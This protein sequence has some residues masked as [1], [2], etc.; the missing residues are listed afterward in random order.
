MRG[1][2]RFILAWCWTSGVLTSFA[3]TNDLIAEIR[4]IDDRTLVRVANTSEAYFVFVIATNVPSLEVNP[5]QAAVV[6]RRSSITDFFFNNTNP[7]QRQFF[8]TIR[9]NSNCDPLDNDNDGIDD[10]IE[11]ILPYL[12]PS[13]RLDAGQDTDGDGWD[14]RTE[15]YLG[16]NPADA[17][18]SYGEI[19]RTRFAPETGSLAFD[20][21]FV[22]SLADDLTSP[23]RA[24]G[25][26]RSGAVWCSLNGDPYADLATVDPFLDL[27]E[28]YLG[29]TDG[30]LSAHTNLPSGAT[31]PLVVEAM[32]LIG[33]PSTDLVIGH[34]D[35]R[36]TFFEG[37]GAGNLLYRPDLTRSNLGAVVALAA[38]DLDGDGDNDLVVSGGAQ[39]TVLFNNDDPVAANA[40]QNGDFADQLRGWS[41]LSGGVV[42]VPRGAAVFE[43]R[44]TFLTGIEQD[45]ILPPAPDALTFDVLEAALSGP[46]GALPDVLEVALLDTEGAPLLPPFRAASESLFNIS[47][48]RDPRLAAGVSIT[49]NRVSINL[50]SVTGDVPATLRF[51][52]IGSPGP[53]ALAAIDNVSI[54]PELVV[55][56][57]WS[58]TAL[59]GPFSQS[60]GLVITDPDLDGDL[61]ILVEDGGLGQL[62]LFENLGTG[63]L[64]RTPLTAADYGCPPSPP[65]PVGFT[66]TVSQAKY[67]VADGLTRQLHPYLAD[68]TSRNPVSTVSGA[69]IQALETSSDG[70]RTWVNHPGSA[71][72]W[73]F[74]ANLIPLGSWIAAGVSN[75]LD[76][77]AAGSDLW[78]LDR[79]VLFLGGDP[80][81]PANYIE[82]HAMLRFPGAVGRV[83]GTATSDFQWLVSAA[84]GDPRHVMSDGLGLHLLDT[85]SNRVHRLDFA[86]TAQGSWALD[87]IN[88]NPRGLTRSG[89][90]IIIADR[91]DLLVYRYPNGVNQSSGT[92]VAVV[93]FALSDSNFEPVDISDPPQN[94]NLDEEVDG[95]FP[96]G[97]EINEYLFV[98]TAPTSILVE[99]ISIVGD[100]GGEGGGFEPAYTL[101]DPDGT[102]LADT[103]Y[104]ERGP[105]NLTET[106]TYSFI[107]TSAGE[108]TGTYTVV[109]RAINPGPAI[110]ITPGE[111]VEDGTSVAG[112]IDRFSFAVSNDAAFYF[113]PGDG[114]FDLLWRL[115]APDGSV[116]TD[117]FWFEVGPVFL[118]A[119]GT[120][121][122]D[123]W[124]LPQNT[125]DYSFTASL[126]ELGSPSNIVF[127]VV[128]SNTLTG[129]PDLDVYTFVVSSQAVIFADYISGESFSTSWDLRGPDT[130]TVFADSF[131]DNSP[132]FLDEP[133]TYTLFIGSSSVTGDYSFSIREVAAPVTSLVFGVNTTGTVAS[134]GG[135][136]R[137]EFTMETNKWLNFQRISGSSGLFQW[138]LL[139]PAGSNVFFMT[140]FGNTGPYMLM[141]TGRYEL[142]IYGRNGG[143]GTVVFRV[144]DLLIQP[145]Q[146]P[147]NIL[148]NTEISATVSNAYWSNRYT[149]VLSE[150]TTLIFNRISGSST[151]F[152][153]RL[154]DPDQNEVFDNS[155]FSLSPEPY[156]ATGTYELVVYNRS[157]VV[158]VSYTFAVE[159]L[160]AQP[161]PEVIFPDLVVTS[162]I[163]EPFQIRTYLID[164][165]EGQ[166]IK[167]EVRSGSSFVYQ[168]EMTDPSSNQIFGGGFSSQDAFIAAT[169]GTYQVQVSAFGSDVGEVSFILYDVPADPAPV[170]LVFDQT[171]GP[172]MIPGQTHTYTFAITNPTTVFFNNEEFSNQNVYVAVNLKSPS[173]ANIFGPGNGQDYGTFVLTEPGTYTLLVEGTLYTGPYYFQLWDVPQHEARAIA[174]EEDVSAVFDAPGE[175][176]AFTFE[177]V[178]GETVY[179]E[180]RYSTNTFEARL[181]GPSGALLKT[182]QLNADMPSLVLP[183][184]GTYR[185]EF[186]F[187]GSVFDPYSGSVAFRLWRVTTIS[188]TLRLSDVMTG[189]IPGPAGRARFTF[190]AAAGE[191]YYFDK[192]DR[193]GDFGQEGGN[194]TADFHWILR[195]PSSAIVFSSAWANAG[196]RIMPENGTYTLEIN[197]GYNRNDRLFQFQVWP[198][199]TSPVQPIARGVV[200]NGAL[201]A[202][203][204]TNR[205]SF[206]AT[207]GETIVV[208][209]FSGVGDVQ[210]LLVSPSGTVLDGPQNDA[211]TS[212]VLAETG[213]FEVRVVDNFATTRHK[214]N[215][216]SFAMDLAPLPLTA[217]ASAD[218]AVTN[219]T[220][221]PVSV[222]T[223]VVMDVVWTV[224]NR[225]ATA[226]SAT[227]WMDRIVLSS[228][229]QLYEQ[230]DEWYIDV[231][232]S[233]GLAGNGFYTA[234]QGVALPPGFEG[235]LFVSVLTDAANVEFESNENN[236]IGLF[237][238]AAIYTADRVLSNSA[239]ID[240]DIADGSRYPQGSTILV[241]GRAS[242]VAASENIVFMLDASG[243]TFIFDQYDANFDGVVDY[244]D[245]INSDLLL[246]PN[247]FAIKG[248]LGSGFD[249][250]LGSIY[251]LAETL[252]ALGSDLRYNILVWA[253]EAVP[254]D[255]S[256]GAFV[257]S[258]ARSGDNRNGNSVVDYKEAS[259]T[260]LYNN[261]PILF[262]SRTLVGGYSFHVF[263]PGNDMQRAFDALLELL[264]RAQPVGRTRVFFLADNNPA[265][266][267]DVSSNTVAQLAA[268]G[269]TLEAIQLIN[270]APVSVPMQRVADIVDADTNST[271]RARALDNSNDLLEA[272]L[273]T[274]RVA[275]VT[276]NDVGVQSFDD[277]GRFF[278]PYVVQ[279]G[280]QDLV[281]KAYD[282]RGNIVSRTVT[283]HGYAGS[284]ATNLPLSDLGEGLSLEYPNATWRAGDAVLDAEM[285]AVNRGVFA[286]RTPLEAWFVGV[287]PAGAQLLAP[288]RVESGGVPVIALDAAGGD[289]AP[290]G[291]GNVFSVSVANPAAERITLE[292]IVYGP[293][294]QAPR[295]VAAPP[296]S[297]IAG[298]AWSFAVAV[299]D[300]EGDPVT[301]ELLDAPAGMIL[302][303]AT[304]QWSTVP[305][306]EGNHLVRVRATDDRGGARE[307]V[308][309][310]AC[311][312]D[313]GNRP[314]VFLSAP[315]T[316]LMSGNNY[317]YTPVVNDPDGDSLAFQLIGSP[318]GFTVNATNG[319]VSYAAIPDGLYALE[320]EADD[321]QGGVTVQAFDLRVGAGSVNVSGPVIL[322]TPPV[323]AVVGESYG[324]FPSAYDP[325]GDAVTFALLQ[326]PSGMT[327]Q[328][329]GGAIQWTPDATQT[330]SFAVLLKVSDPSG[331]YASQ[332]FTIQSGTNRLNRAPVM[333]REPLR[334]ATAGTLYEAVIAAVDPDGEP[335]NYSLELGPAGMAVD[336]GTG[337]VSWS[338]PPLLE[339]LV[340]ARVYAV[341][342][343]G[344][345]AYLTWYPDVRASNTPPQFTGAPATNVPAGALYRQV[346]RVVDAEDGVTFD[347]ITDA[348]GLVIDERTGVLRWS[349]SVQDIGVYTVTVTATDDRGLA[350]TWTYSLQVVPDTTAP[351]VTLT[352]TP[353]L[354]DVGETSVVRVAASDDVGVASLAILA[355]ASNLVVDGNGEAMVVAAAPG[356]IMVTGLAVDAAGNTGTVA[357]AL[358]VIDPSDT[359]TPVII[360]TAPTNQATV[361]AWTEI[362][363][364][365]T[366]PEG[367]LDYFTV[368][369]APADALEQVPTASGFA[370]D[371]DCDACFTEVFRTNTPVIDDTLAFLD[372]SLYANNDYAIRVKAFDVNG[373]G[374]TE[375]VII[376]IN[377][378]IKPGQFIYEV[379]DLLIPTPG[380]PIEIGRRYDSLARERL[381]GMGYGWSL[382]AEDPDI[383]ETVRD[384]ALPYSV[385][386]PYPLFDG[387]RVYLTDPDGFRIGFTFAPE[388][389]QATLLA[390]IYDAV[391]SSD[392]GVRDLLRDGS[393]DEPKVTLREDGTAR[394][395]LLN[396]PY[397]PYEYDLVRP[398]GRTYRYRQQGGLM[399]ITDEL[400]NEVTFTEDQVVHSD[401]QAVTIER[402][403][404]GRVTRVID[405]QGRA[406]VY[407][408][409]GAG[410]LVAV[411]DREGR[412]TRYVYAEEPAHAL[413]AIIDPQG[414]V[415]QQGEF[416][417]AGR[418]TAL[419]GGASNGVQRSFDP[420]SFT[421]VDRDEFG[422]ETVVT[423][424]SDGLIVQKDHPDGT[425]S[426]YTYDDRQ[427]VVEKNEHGVATYYQYDAFD[428][429]V[430]VS[431]AAGRALFMTYDGLGRLTAISNKV[432]AL[433]AMGVNSNGQPESIELANG[434]TSSNT[435]DAKGRIV[436]RVNNRGHATTFEYGASLNVPEKVVWP[437][438]TFRSF[439]WGAAGNLASMM[440][441]AGYLTFFDS[442]SDNLITQVVDHAGNVIVLGYDETTKEVARWVDPEGHVFLKEN[443]FDTNE[444]LRAYRYVRGNGETAVHQVL[445]GLPGA[446]TNVIG[447]GVSNIWSF[448]RAGGTTTI[449]NAVG[450]VQT[451]VREGERIVAITDRL[452]REIIRRYDAAGM[453]T[454]EVWKVGGLVT[455]DI[456]IVYSEAGYVDRVSDYSATYTYQRDAR[457]RFVTYTAAGS[458]GV[459]PVT[460]HYGY[461]AMD[462]IASMS[463]SLG[464]AYG[465]VYDDKEVLTSR[466]WAMPGH[467]SA[468]VDTV[469]DARD[470]PVRIDRYADSAA[471]TASVVTL[472]AWDYDMEAVSI[473][474]RQ[475]GTSNLLTSYAY[476][477]QPAGWLSQVVHNAETI[478]YDHDPIGQLL[479]ADRSAGTDEVFGWAD[480]NPTGSNTVIGY[481]NRLLRR[482]D[483]HMA[484]DAEGNML[485]RSNA[486]TGTS[487]HFAYDVLDRL[488]HL[489]ERDG[490]GAVVNTVAYRYDAFNRRLARTHN[491]VTVY[492]V[493]DFSQPLADVDGS[494]QVLAVYLNSDV[495]DQRYGRYRAGEG[496]AW[497]L[498]DRLQNVRDIADAQGDVVCT[499][500]YSAFGR[501]LSVSDPA[502][503]DRFLWAG[504]MYEPVSA[505]YDFY[506]RQYDPVIE[507]FTSQD[508]AAYRP[509]DYHR[510]RYAFNAPVDK[511]DLLGF[512]PA[513]E[514]PWPLVVQSFFVGCVFSVG[515]SLA[516]DA[517]KAGAAA[518][519]GGGGATL[520]QEFTGEKGGN[521][522]TAYLYDCAIG[523]L[524]NAGT[525]GIAGGAGGRAFTGMVDD[526]LELEIKHA[527]GAA[528]REANKEFVKDAVSGEGLGK[529]AVKCAIGAGV[530]GLMG[531]NKPPDWFTKPFE[532]ILTW[533]FE[534]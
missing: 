67:F 211:L 2:T 103:L 256:P 354:L 142:V 381:A 505:Q 261:P 379:T 345:R 98:V 344:A 199:I 64:A 220:V 223:A 474:H 516:C 487:F 312:E 291:T 206:P 169:S 409:D 54:S 33:D 281:I 182:Q 170:S 417:Q 221:P 463:N 389:S 337:T 85:T 304:L 93:A 63:V 401:G 454:Q 484:Y 150:P 485:V 193:N 342:A 49:S 19:S 277:S 262:S 330:G 350:S 179:L 264:D 423:F 311:E 355:G 430:A 243:S 217:P 511:V 9:S 76:L 160:A 302:N 446:V 325:D 528:M 508:P 410:D 349:T 114:S 314:P 45:I 284:S 17:T 111:L 92:G 26:G 501:T 407:A 80:E 78:V 530:D 29:A 265:A 399:A 397:N 124:D 371:L 10:V 362:T 166:K 416:D 31:G 450:D 246:Y 504:R 120:Y 453:L 367:N 363:G 174:F 121:Y 84:I 118:N 316:A 442:N 366:D 439:T 48:A 214:R 448:S 359:N 251:K 525:A 240:T 12:D 415:L 250:M 226:T 388:F 24:A 477:Y 357:R 172:V 173:S 402:D 310:I 153:W 248:A 15:L 50:A 492:T 157:G 11:S 184:G 209:A 288:D 386:S 445:P 412:T 263:T 198:S 105:Y 332:F 227:G 143:S 387:A 510:Y 279:P 88:A 112:E 37:D 140:F 499:I 370:L 421:G 469:N 161:P 30:T 239:A 231:A 307:L 241:S 68:G 141:E 496:V 230:G 95:G 146:T 38:A 464:M 451:V 158:P 194:S 70:S 459:P 351:A 106:G 23:F 82:Q 347:V 254:L 490:V 196:T 202:P 205:Y 339:G 338:V 517:A 473:E 301:L 200:V 280:A 13:N 126:V 47:A 507:R 116:A 129:P 358:R 326:A 403:G 229:A 271:G 122:L 175:I 242:A 186:S 299:E 424:N 177:G 488:V 44:G 236:N 258:F 203:G 74:D 447:H 522:A 235:E 187:N 181:Y 228:D 27:V 331:A 110:P 136:L 125:G 191:A 318:P 368:E 297:V 303:G 336:A 472:M 476:A 365:V 486:Q 213:T 444:V 117:G 294:N 276:V 418:M 320:L 275:G 384:D 427:R 523:G 465:S 135:M 309:S 329:A 390:L 4:V 435:Y 441:E 333:T 6:A 253:S 456:R 183:T 22:L 108:L 289:L 420:G 192:Q 500:D 133:G 353:S 274:L 73:V 75:L 382:L 139:D 1:F 255:S 71:E 321:G 56:E 104:W 348:P 425:T 94:I 287:D 431:N 372:P 364:S 506:F 39:V 361:A 286:Q 51:A 159:E 449:A 52:L 190:E 305:G 167:P 96:L 247:D 494:N 188:S 433:I 518:L 204:V 225:S 466:T 406:I 46:D 520:V 249:L 144:N 413:I 393:I 21:G 478:V 178:A 102:N 272:L 455:N 244:L 171:Y 519:A 306:D 60:G 497:Y 313:A 127:D 375:G 89:A 131:F 514:Y 405:P 462:N 34:T 468:R 512:G 290:G 42:S 81:N 156:T 151:H 252:D 319:A 324:Y 298:Q 101:N 164:L 97:N 352:L 509:G 317:L 91:D 529:A 28:V 369:I 524:M 216:F 266:D 86:G 482:G 438:D 18:D 452:G 426:S 270:P 360:I 149:F 341:D 238:L 36:I 87:V 479:A 185:I 515:E 210:Y 232:R 513:I 130:N 234:T 35:G 534:L 481:E 57:G 322:T 8:F 128:Y 257:Q 493:Y 437:D 440:D 422:R 218:L 208:D 260:I 419:S 495:A 59:T 335:V 457:N 378:A 222:G 532:A 215:R 180:N 377:G 69:P 334:F 533:G 295:F 434:D 373:Q 428:Q 394:L 109:L 197:G 531:D 195:A 315:E 343:G 526:A 65:L 25:N 521:K 414:R 224:S 16:T 138:E 147:S 404:L 61:D 323:V 41:V 137:Y 119:T 245:D 395:P 163:A 267:G 432:G 55:N 470:L 155:M 201:S 278:T 14:D 77:A 328:A 115:V 467:F 480:G 176:R 408:Y 145:E 308:F 3:Q 268:R 283:I 237:D 293:A 391:F 162:N 491:G 62:I 259:Q 100:P 113:A 99:F 400:G 83:T 123:V 383:R 233:G 458:N 356:L 43:E 165:T 219:V 327:I 53:D 273:D 134:A 148:L 396:V 300:D 269:V 207:A 461:D 411:T 498:A 443:I 189:D 7:A 285:A 107:V 398:D 475:G 527:V 66:G 489:E 20:G 340:T 132:V 168:W 374:R 32:N 292:A 483:W 40:V 346:V 392:P 385:I 429:V 502:K 436:S 90:D 380:I 58:A 376:A 503:A 5:A 79:R 282:T 154:L 296:A 72:V 471:A 212:G 460:M 152:G